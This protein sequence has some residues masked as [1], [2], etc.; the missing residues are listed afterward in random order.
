MRS[1]VNI[2][3]NSQSAPTR[4]SNDLKRDSRDYLTYL[5]WNLD[6]SIVGW[7]QD[8]VGQEP[9][10]DDQDVL[11]NIMDPPGCLLCGQLPVGG[12]EASAPGLRNMA[13]NST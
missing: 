3:T 9:A 1:S 11:I 8:H 6:W 13:K 5:I 7:R 12:V 10:D 4:L 2:E